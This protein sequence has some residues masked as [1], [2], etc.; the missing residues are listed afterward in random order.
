M[1]PAVLISLQLITRLILTHSLK[2]SIYVSTILVK[3]YYLYIQIYCPSG[4]IFAVAQEKTV[5]M[6][7]CFVYNQLRTNPCLKAWSYTTGNRGE[8]CEVAQ[9]LEEHAQ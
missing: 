8:R 2:Q 3:W 4:Y 5:L 9:I 6:C 7:A 1:Q